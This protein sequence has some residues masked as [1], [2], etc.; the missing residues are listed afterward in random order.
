MSKMTPIQDWLNLDHF[1]EHEAKMLLR[2]A[3]ANLRMI[4]DTVAN[5]L[6]EKQY[7]PQ[8]HALAAGQ[9]KGFLLNWEQRWDDSQP[10]VAK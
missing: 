6:D 7:S 3:V 1:T 2:M 4:S 5:P 8:G 10:K 9:A